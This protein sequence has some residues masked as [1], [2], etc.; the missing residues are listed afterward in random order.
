M[1]VSPTATGAV[2]PKQDC[3]LPLEHLQVQ[4]RHR[5]L[6]SERLPQPLNGDAAPLFD[7]LGELC[8]DRFHLRARHHLAVDETFILLHPPLPLVGVSIVMERGCQPNDSL[9]SG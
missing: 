8:A 6:R 3:D 2:V 4:V 1:T 9:V 5:H 7:L